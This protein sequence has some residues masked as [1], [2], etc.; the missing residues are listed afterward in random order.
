[1]LGIHEVEHLF[2]RVQGRGYALFQILLLFT[3]RAEHG[4]YDAEPLIHLRAGQ[5]AAI[6]VFF[7]AAEKPL[8]V[9]DGVCQVLSLK[10]QRI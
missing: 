6:G 3:Q 1:M 8:I 10:V 4:L 2:G 9:F 7:K 5:A